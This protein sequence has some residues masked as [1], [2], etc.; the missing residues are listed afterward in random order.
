[1]RGA[2][3]LQYGTQFGGLLNFMLR[4]PAPDRKVQLLARQTVGSFGFYNTFTSLSGTVK[5]LSYYT[6]F[7]YKSGNGWRPNSQFDNYNFYTNIN[8]QLSHKTKVGLDVTLMDYL[9][10]QPGGLSDRMFNQD[11]RQSIRERNWFKVRW[12][13]L[14]LHFNHKFNA[15]NEFNIR[16]FSLLAYRNSLGFRPNRVETIDDH[17]ERDLIKGNFL[18]WGAE[19]RYL[20]RY[21]IRKRP[22]VLLLGTRYYHGFNHS[23]QGQGSK[24]KDADFNYVQDNIMIYDYR[25]PNR[26]L[27]F[28]VEHIF[29]LSDRWSITP[30]IR[31]EFIH[32]TAEGYYG[33]IVRD[34]A[35]GIIDVKRIHENRES[36]RDFAL[37]GIGLSYKPIHKLNAYANISQNYRS[38]TFSDMRISN[39][40]FVIDPHMTDE[41]GYSFDLGVRSEHTKHF[42][43]DV[44]IFYLS[45]NNRIGEFLTKDKDKR[46]VRERGNIG[47]AAIMGI[48]S[49]AEGD[50]IK[51]FKPQVKHYSSLLYANI[52]IIESKYIETKIP[53]AKGNQVEFVP[54]FN[55]KTGIKLGFKQFKA[56]F[57]TTYVADQYSD[58]TN[59]TKS[60]VSAVTGLIPAYTIM[61]LSLSYEYKFMKLEGSINNL[62]DQMYF[63]RRATGYPGPG[64]LPSDGRSFYFT[65]QV[66]F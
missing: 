62:V 13:M 43:Y 22:M 48:E 1:V 35:G 50:L 64:I 5:K 56:C 52:A 57:Q 58:V 65:L 45:Y 12:N 28:F 51:L 8:Y 14:A 38:I 36:A 53:G 7:Q 39:P 21:H 42:N 33:S 59:A 37:G 23:T 18:N 16:L 41:R 4:K 32:T 9:A 19:A 31:Y 55:I 10:K 30:G 61:D 47:Q 40:S 6:Y 44:S 29:Y 25:F 15:S 26:N 11:P 27:A 24:G 60:D 34:L 17:G 66:K 49:Y 46:P 54:R 3:S 2:A 63:T 20:K